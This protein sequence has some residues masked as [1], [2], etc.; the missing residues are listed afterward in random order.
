MPEPM[1]RRGVYD[2]DE[3]DPLR[4]LLEQCPRLGDNAFSRVLSARKGVE[5]RR[6]R[7]G[8]L[9]HFQGPINAESP[10]LLHCIDIVAPVP[11]WFRPTSAQLIFETRLRQEASDD[12][13]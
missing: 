3:F 6:H 2:Y 12:Q 5:L 9:R 4:R 10:I 1:R 13:A 8:L 11:P 7:I